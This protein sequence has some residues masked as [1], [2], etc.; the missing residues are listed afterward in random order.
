MKGRC[1]VPRSTSFR[2]FFHR[3]EDHTWRYRHIFQPETSMSRPPASCFR[4]SLII[5][6][7]ESW[8]AKLYCILLRP[9]LGLS[10]VRIAAESWRPSSAARPNGTFLGTPIF[11]CQRGCVFAPH[12]IIHTFFRFARNYFRI[13][14]N[15]F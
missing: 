14:Q 6:R 7:S 13:F 10:L 11:S 3:T 5:L 12:P 15:I 1:R 2:D 8:P 4:R 9:W